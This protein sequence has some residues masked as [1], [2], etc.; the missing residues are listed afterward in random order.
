MEPDT[1][2]Q[3]IPAAAPKPTMFSVPVALGDRTITAYVDANTQEEAQ[4]LIESRRERVAKFN[5]RENVY[6][7]RSEMGGYGY[8]YDTA[9]E[10]TA[11][12]NVQK[13]MAN[14]DA[15]ARFTAENAELDSTAEN[16][17]GAL[18]VNDI[19]SDIDAINAEAAQNAPKKSIGEM[20]VS[21]GKDIAFGV[22]VEGPTQVLAG[23]AS[24]IN[25]TLDAIQIAGNAL[26]EIIPNPY[27]VW[28]G[29]GDGVAGNAQFRVG[30]TGRGGNFQRDAEALG[31]DLNESAAPELPVVG[32]QP[33]SVTGGVV[34][35]LSQFGASMGV[36]GRALRNWKTASTVGKF[37]K[38]MVAGAIADFAAFDESDKRLSDLI[39]TVP[40]LSNPVTE[41]L[42]SDEDDTAL[43]SRLKNVVEGGLIGVGLEAIGPMVKQ[44]SAY[45]QL[46]KAQA[47][48]KP[49]A[50]QLMAE[51]IAAERK[52]VT[53][54]NEAVKILGDPEADLVRVKATRK[55]AD[56][57]PIEGNATEAAALTRTADAVGGTPQRPQD[58]A[59]AAGLNQFDPRNDVILERQAPGTIIETP[60]TEP[61]GDTRGRG[62]QFH[63]TTGSISKLMPENYNNDNIYGN[64]G[65]YTTDAVDIAKGYQRK[66]DSGVVY[67]VAETKPVNFY[68]MEQFT[69]REEIR[70]LA[71]VANEGDLAANVNS[72]VDDAL[73]EIGPDGGGLRSF[74]DAV[75]DLAPVHD[76]DPLTV[77][78]VI[79]S[80]ILEKIKSQ[81]YGG[82]RHIGGSLTKNRPHTVKIYFDPANQISMQKV[83][84]DR[85]PQTAAKPDAAP[86]FGD[87]PFEI[88]FSKIAQPDDV[89]SVIAQMIESRP[90]AIDAARRG[91]QTWE[92]SKAGAE[93]V[94]QS[95]K[96]FVD[97]LSRRPGQAANDKE[98]IAL[99]MLW[100]ESGKKLREVAK[101]AAD[102]PTDANM[103]VFRQMLS[104]HGTIEEAAMGARA[105]A[106]RSLQT[107]RMPV[108]SSEAIATRVREL[109]NGS[110]GALRQGNIDL[111]RQ[112]G[113]L[114]DSTIG[115]IARKIPQMTDAQR[116]RTIIQA[117]MLTAPSTHVANIT[118]NA[119]GMTFETALRAL[120]PMTTGGTGAVKK[121]EAFAMFAGQLQAFW[122]VVRAGDKFKAF[123]NTAEK[124]GGKAE[125]NAQHMF[126]KMAGSKNQALRAVA[127]VGDFL[128]KIPGGAT[129][130]MDNVFKYALTSGSMNATA[131]RKAMDEVNA[132]A[133]DREDLIKRQ[134]ELVANPT[135]DMIDEAGRLS[136]EAT[137]SRSQE[138]WTDSEGKSGPGWGKI[139]LNIRQAAERGGPAGGYASGVIM[140]FINTPAN[141][142]SYAF[143]S[144]PLAPMM[145]RYQK[146]LAEGGARAEIARTR[147]MAGSAIMWTAFSLAANGQLS[148]GGPIDP[149]QRQ[150]LQRQGW[151]PYSVRVGDTWYS[152]S[153]L[154]PMGTLFSIA[155]DLGDIALNTDWADMDSI[156]QWSEIAATAV[157]AIGNAYVNKSML[158]GAADLFEFMGDPKRYG[159]QF[160]LSKLSAPI[161]AAVGLGERLGD[162][163]AR[164][165]M[166]APREPGGANDIL[167]GLESFMQQ[168][169]TR[170]P[171]VSETL[172]IRRDMWGRPQMQVSGMGT[173]WEILSPSRASKNKWEPIDGELERLKYYPQNMQRTLTLPAELTAGPGDDRRYS[174]ADRPDIYNRILEVRGEII[175]PRLNA[176]VNGEGNEGAIYAAS[177]D[178][179][180]QEMIED[181]IGEGSK[182]AR[183][184]V[185]QEYYVD[186][187]AMSAKRANAIGVAPAPV[188]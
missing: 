32:Q 173:A 89:N 174:L 105:E 50:D 47:Q 54:L 185:I 5:P 128:V 130:A 114:D 15:V 76:V 88:N 13:G 116:M 118:G 12:S 75:R 81:G 138:T 84:F 158:S 51:T 182:I 42:A 151:Q 165:P 137:F 63:G 10:A 177:D 27:V 160:I 97:L 122:D 64:E 166:V 80:G 65:F 135:D 134:R 23:A 43:E 21:A 125:M 131:F 145:A 70:K 29:V 143:R 61:I 90:D 132:G 163:Y 41:W 73:N 183:A 96:A 39:E 153:R 126:P 78:E 149:Q 146:D 40:E 92:Q 55:A 72:L 155:S 170:I 67:Q 71:A 93:A 152:Y 136:E 60:R 48:I 19:M 57:S 179:A 34:R 103:M 25:E 123:W 66:S 53:D 100:G 17:Y 98:T 18:E 184:Q 187:A 86:S 82:M 74:M 3:A 139:M 172:P 7:M 91:V 175:L 113:A 44:I 117:A 180:K 188:E 154:D 144:S 69:P 95:D 107:W 83:G 176:M 109:V 171:G 133:L 22:G 161:P 168:A 150:L 31:V 140:P 124:S 1:V 104:V 169:K 33:T 108:G 26:S 178:V 147:M 119:M 167:S 157:G 6:V 77:Q 38:A 159:E 101:L 115:E 14:M 28:S 35:A 106:G 11:R 129:N 110:D 2:D 20:A 121:G 30:M 79:F 56:M 58:A 68:D 4:A 37:S 181:V 186:L 62:V 87:N 49:Q 141:I 36:A 46:K 120:A 24:G 8:S 59:Q 156:E 94:T 102:N 112:I 45:R 9:D 127:N 111:A 85:K 162:P 142:M 164:D 52:V 148:G 99:R 16:N